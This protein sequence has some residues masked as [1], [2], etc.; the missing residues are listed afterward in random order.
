MTNTIKADDWVYVVVQDPGKAETIVGQRDADHNI[1]FIPVFRTKDE[2]H[3]GVTQMV[4]TPGQVIE[5][6]AILYEDVLHY[7]SNGGFLLFIL[8][9][10]GRILSKVSPDGRPL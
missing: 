8:D 2:A 10:A 1:D 5:I 4:R 7:A 3:Q 9:G 6:Q